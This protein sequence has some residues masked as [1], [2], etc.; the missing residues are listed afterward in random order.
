MRSRS[1]RKAGRYAEIAAACAAALARDGHRC[2]A[3]LLVPEVACGGPLDPQHVIP[4]GVDKTL[5]A[6]P[7]NIV[8]CCRQHHEWIGDNPVAARAVGLHGRFG[9]DLAQLAAARILAP[10]R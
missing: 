5:A 1:P 7:A 6:D 8:A 9:D 3:R 2:Q 10:P 4:Q